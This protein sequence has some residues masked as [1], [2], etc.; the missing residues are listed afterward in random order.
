VEEQV[1]AVLKEPELELAAVNLPDEKKGERIV[2]L[3]A[4]EIEP[5]ALR[6]ALLAAGANPLTIPAEV[7]RVEAIPKLGSGKT[8]FAGIKRLALAA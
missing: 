8:D 7:R 3:V 6:A 1:R 5:D 4:A 2:L